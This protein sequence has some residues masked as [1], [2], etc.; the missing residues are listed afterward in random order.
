LW[1]RERRD[2]IEQIRRGERS[3][4]ARLVREQHPRIYAMLVHLTRDRHAAEDLCQETFA[5]AWAGSGSFAGDCA[6]GTWLYRIAYRKFLDARRGRAAKSR[7]A[8]LDA[9]ASYSPDPLAGLL[10]EE[11]Q[12]ALHDAM[13][14]IGDDAARAA[15]VLHYLQ[16]LSY[17]EMVQVTGEPVGTVK[18]RTKAALEQL[19]RL[20][21]AAA[22]TT[23]ND[24]STRDQRAD[25]AAA[26]DAVAADT[27]G[28]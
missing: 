19:G 4:W 18:W 11:Q 14:R 1:R 5:A 27:S 26:G 8:Q 15:I 22:T 28:T 16:G 6:I 25:P 23:R 21:G 13:A 20:L 3:A 10:I 9:E 12:R 24:E 2:W 17:R 7:A